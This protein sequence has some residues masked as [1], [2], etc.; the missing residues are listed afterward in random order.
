MWLFIFIVGSIIVSFIING[1]FLTRINNEITS[2]KLDL[3]KKQEPIK[4]FPELKEETKQNIKEIEITRLRCESMKQLANEEGYNLD[5]WL[6]ESC[7]KF[8]EYDNENYR[9]LKYDCKTGNLNCY[10]LT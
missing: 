8:C 4:E 2:Q 9:Y 5:Y 1:D 7:R 6:S 10:C 3:N